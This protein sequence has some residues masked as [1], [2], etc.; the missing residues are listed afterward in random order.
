[1]TDKPRDVIVPVRFDEETLATDL[2]HLPDAAGA[3]MAELRRTI[4]RDGGLPKSRLKR[5]EP[6]GRD[7]TR[8][9]SATKTY[10]PW[11]DG[12]WGIVFQAVAHPIRPWG[13]RVLAYGRRHPTGPGQLSVYEIA[14][15]RLAEIIA[16]DLRERK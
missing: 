2:E 14:D 1:M 15:R 8:L 4:D 6:E 11:P 13:L 3:T 7:G 9:P 12:P 5:C 16:T 10:I